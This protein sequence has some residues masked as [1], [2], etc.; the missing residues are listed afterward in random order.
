M[1]LMVTMMTMMTMISKPDFKKAEWAAYKLL[2][3]NGINELPVKVKELAKI[4]P[5]LKI[6]TYSWFGKDSGKSIDEVCSFAHSNEGCCYYKSDVGQYIILYNDTVK[7]KGRIR[8]TVAHELGH[9]ILKHNEI[10]D[11][12]VLARSSLTQTEYETFEK[13]A[14]CFARSLLAP[15][16]VLLALER[17]ALSDVKELCN[18]SKEASINTLKFLNEGVK[19]G[20]KF[21]P[22]DALVKLFSD[23][24]FAKNNEH[25]CRN[26]KCVFIFSNP[27][28][29]PVCGSKKLKRKKGG[30]YMKYNGFTLD[31]NGRALRCPKCDNEEISNGE[32]CKICGVN[33]VNRC[34]NRYF[35]VCTG[36]EIINCSELAEGNAR[37]CVHCGHK[38]TFFEKSLLDDWEN[39]IS[40]E[41]LPF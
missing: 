9:F 14:D 28:Y 23:F 37:Y 15:Q 11:K 6:K 5:N 33:I 12:T 29:C 3:D 20:R 35:D 26:C 19:L 36:E 7:N 32:Y 24:I 39:T 16:S 4:Y 22:N 30:T 17:L 18:L 2:Y 41:D 21:D 27:S 8:W 38:T 31:E 1:H 25:Q 13:E 34:A 40:D 10:T